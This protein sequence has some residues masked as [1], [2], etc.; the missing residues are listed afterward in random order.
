MNLTETA[1]LLTTIA[2]FS[3]RNVEESAV[4]AWQSVLV[5]I[6]LPDA[7]EAARRHFSVSADW[8]MPVH[9][10]QG[11]QQVA[12]ERAKAA[13]KWAP[14]QYGVPHTMPVPEVTGRIDEGTLPPKIRELL[15]EVRAMLPEGS[16]EA[17]MPRQVAW[18]R[19][20]ADRDR[21]RDSEPNPHYNP[22]ATAAR[23]ACRENGPHDDGCHIGTCPDAAPVGECPG[24]PH[25]GHARPEEPCPLNA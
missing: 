4:V 14:G 20:Q 17:L 3:N 24:T 7:E 5:D 10:R 16:R 1:Q 19:Q 15:A 11:A 18:E 21:Q 8:M 22:A 25:R 13:R 6:S 2:A 12:E 23:Q 9:I